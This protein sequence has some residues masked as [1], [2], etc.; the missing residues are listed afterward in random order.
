MTVCIVIE[1]VRS[2]ELDKVIDVFIS[3]PMSGK[4]RFEIWEERQRIIDVVKDKHPNACIV[5]SI[6]PEL[7]DV[8]TLYYLA[9]SLSMMSYCELVFF[10]KGWENERGCIIE[11]MCAVHYGYRIDYEI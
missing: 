2:E 6:L 10:A 3:Q 11:H 1:H 8:P 5:D 4:S 7:K 9:K